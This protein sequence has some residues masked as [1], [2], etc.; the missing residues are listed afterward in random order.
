M[1]IVVIFNNVLNLKHSSIKYIYS[2]N[3]ILYN[4]LLISIIKINIEY[5]LNI[6]LYT[7]LNI[8]KITKLTK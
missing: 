6:L 1:A 2:K 3:K 4:I 7:T 5:F 8:K